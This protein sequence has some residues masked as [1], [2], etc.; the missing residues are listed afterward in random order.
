MDVTIRRF[1]DSDADPVRN[2]FISVNRLLAPAGMEA[3]FESYIAR[4]L[5]DE[6][7]R[8]SAYYGERGGSFWVAICRSK[9]VGMFGLEPASPGALE[10]RRMYVDPAA[11][12]RGVASLML[13]FAEQQCKRSTANLLTLSTS[14][15]QPAA[16]NFYRNAGY[17]LVREEFAE[18]TSNKTIGGG[19]RRY[20]FK[21]IISG[22]VI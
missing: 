14:E 20:Y 13:Q 17:R 9:L 3:A 21:K 1:T 12:R 4:S 6:M 2:L 11:R 7:N 16:I 18:Q 10:L 5:T 19:I 15:L 8:V 22:E